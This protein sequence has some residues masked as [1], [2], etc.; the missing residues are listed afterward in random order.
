[1]PLP[2]VVLVRMNVNQI[3]SFRL[4][5]VGI[6]RRP[7]D[8][9]QREE[10]HL[11]HATAHGVEGNPNV[12]FVAS[13]TPAFGSGKEGVRMACIKSAWD[14]LVKGGYLL[15]DIHLIP[16]RKNPEMDVLVLGLQKDVPELPFPSS[17]AKE[18]VEQFLKTTWEF[19]HVWLNPP[20]STGEVVH[21][22]NC[23]H[24]KADK[25]SEQCL[26]INGDGVWSLSAP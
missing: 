17:R 5:E 14:E 25:G 2:D 18:R 6:E 23:M 15:K 21:T 1:M 10:K 3:Q 8:W 9:L 4:Q 11:E 22:V 12:S 13:G 20:Q 16:H 26:H 7:V 24:R 19:V